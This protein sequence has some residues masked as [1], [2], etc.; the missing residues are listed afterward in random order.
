M[1]SPSKNTLVTDPMDWQAGRHLDRLTRPAEPSGEDEAKVGQKKKN[2]RKAPT[3]SHQGEL[4]ST[5][6]FHFKFFLVFFF[7]SSNSFSFY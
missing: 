7:F 2:P 6:Q 3:Q 5:E 1:K 4:P